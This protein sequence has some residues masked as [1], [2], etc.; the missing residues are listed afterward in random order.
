MDKEKVLDD[1]NQDVKDKASNDV[2]LKPTGG[3]INLKI[4]K[5]SK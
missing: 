4:D 3:V 1:F 2:E 5:V